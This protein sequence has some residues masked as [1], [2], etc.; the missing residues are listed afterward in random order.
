MSRELITSTGVPMQKR[1]ALILGI[2]LALATLSCTG[3]RLFA[4]NP[5]PQ[6]PSTAVAESDSQETAPT[7][8]PPNT[9]TPL[10]T[11]PVQ[12]GSADE[13]VLITGSIELTNDLFRAL[14]TE[15]YVVLTDS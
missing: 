8:P 5:T 11:S 3:I 4:Q 7:F 13:P 14:A 12:A 15:P 1:H 6:P 10:A 2:T 9:P